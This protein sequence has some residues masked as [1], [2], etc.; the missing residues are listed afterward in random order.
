MWVHGPADL[1]PSPALVVVLHGCSQTAEGY[2]SG[3]GWLE[4]ADRYGFVVLCP[5]QTAANNLQ[6]CFNWFQPGDNARGKG[7]AASIK[8]M[9]TQAVGDYGV[10]RRHVFITGL[11]AGGAMTSVMLAAYPE[12]FAG[13]GIVAGLA[14]GAAHDM[15]T[16][17]AAMFQC[18]VRSEDQL[19]DTVRGASGHKGPWPRI[20]IWHGSADQTVVPANADEIAKQWSSLHGATTAGSSVV[21]GHRRSAWSVNGEDVIELY[22]LEGLGHGAPLSTLGEDGCGA[23][24]PFLLEAG[25]SSSLEM[26]KFW[27]IT[28][29]EPRRQAREIPIPINSSFGLKPPIKLDVQSVINRALTAAGLL[30]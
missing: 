19:R 30:K 7:E 29:R 25:V 10:D 1:E 24:G 12:V 17:F 20:S 6:G 15:P 2:A 8:S 4:L 22:A 21:C 14:H 3:A 9:I 11:S 5:E 26:A 27:R 28:S 23:T 18:P 13:G 16:A